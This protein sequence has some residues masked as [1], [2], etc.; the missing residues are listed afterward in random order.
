MSSKKR[1]KWYFLQPDG[2]SDEPQASLGGKTPLQYAKTPHLDRLTA[3][4]QCYNLRS[5]PEGYPPGSD[6][7]NL[8]LL[9]YD[10]RN[11]FTGRSPIEAA[12]MGISLGEGEYAFRCNLIHLQGSGDNAVMLDFSAGHISTEEATPII[13]DLAKVLPNVRLNPGVSYRHAL[14][15]KV[16]GA[17]LKTTPPHDIQDQKVGPYLPKG[18]AAAL[19]LEW[20]HLARGVLRDHPINQARIAKGELPATDIWVWGQGK[21]TTL[22]PLAERHDG[23]TGAMITAVDLLRGLAVLTG[24]ENIKV[25]G[26]T[27][28]IDTNYRGK[29]Q[30]AIASKKDLVFL[31]LEAPDESS[32]MGNTEYKVTALERFD[33]EIVAPIVAAAEAERAGIIV[34]PD[35]PT[36]LRTKGHALAN[37]PCIAWTPDKPMQGSAGGYHEGLLQSGLAL[38]GW[39]LLDDVRQRF[40]E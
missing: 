27:G 31:H 19:C 15:A 21:A 8:S 1:R 20:M 25:E 2:A 11:Y 28:F 37:V 32:H 33:A 36:L 5:I 34:T 30:A 3:K 26:A 17:D 18:K 35:H 4:A 10:P 39:V 38:D 22:K 7:G 24:M 12:A 23:W 14:I 29:A 6:I 13:R 40:G 16:D 9:G